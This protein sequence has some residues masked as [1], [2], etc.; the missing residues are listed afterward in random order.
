[1][2]GAVFDDATDLW[3][4]TTADGKRLTSRYLVNALGLLAKSNM[5]RHPGP[6]QLRRAAG[7]HQRLAG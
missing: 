1:M 7:A 3:T 6:G 2:T 4:V 5:P